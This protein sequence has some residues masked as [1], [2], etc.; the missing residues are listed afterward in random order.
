MTHVLVV[1]PHPDDETL[2]C[3]GT[4]LKHKANN[5]TL[6]WLIATTMHAGLGLSDSR[7]IARKN[8]IKAVSENYGFSSVFQLDFPAAAIET[9]SM[10][11][12]VSEFMN[13][14][15]KVW[16]EIVYLPHQH[17]IHTDHGIVFKAAAACIKWFRCPSVKKILCYETLSETEY[18]VSNTG[19]FQ[20]N[21]FI[22]I[23]PYLEQKIATMELYASEVR[24]FPFPR[25][26]EA[27]KALAAMRGS[28]CGCQA[29]EAFMLLKE[30]S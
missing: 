4:L 20:P 16:P 8:E 30:I 27:I 22:D 26:F 3:G 5:D 2:G 14:F 7:M 19:R 6:F 12:L 29:A 25:S 15:Q 9:L 11:S 28:M 10:A 1:A 21:V 24:P 18:S 13:V 17:D 23:T